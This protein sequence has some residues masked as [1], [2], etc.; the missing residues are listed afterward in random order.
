MADD[1]DKLAK[2]MADR[3]YGD[4]ASDLADG[5]ILA[6]AR[7][8]EAK[9]NAMIERKDTLRVLFTVVNSR[10]D[11]TYSFDTDPDASDAAELAAFVVQAVQTF[12]FDS[13]TIVPPLAEKVVRSD[14][15]VVEYDCVVLVSWGEKKVYS[16][17]VDRQR[18]LQCLSFIVEDLR[19][20]APKKPVN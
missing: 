3:I 18:Q 19:K 1:I 17:V 20:K 2:R 6:A 11:Y 14:G 9:W 12:D 4:G 7:R 8:L 5:A 16:N 10:L 13:L 15:T